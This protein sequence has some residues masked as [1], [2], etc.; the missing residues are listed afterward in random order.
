MS[1][2]TGDL[3]VRPAVELIITSRSWFYEKT[4]KMTMIPAKLLHTEKS[5]HTGRNEKGSTTTDTEEMFSKFKR[6][7]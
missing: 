4:N 6:R 5:R 1:N 2:K 3:G 7:K